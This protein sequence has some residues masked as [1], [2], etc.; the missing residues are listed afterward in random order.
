MY[1]VFF[2]IRY[3]EILAP[4]IFPGQSDLLAPTL[5]MSR[6]ILLLPLCA[7]YDRLWGDLY[8]YLESKCVLLSH[9]VAEPHSGPPPHHS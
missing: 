3:Y 2:I 9:A 4:G 1:Q 7:S 6:A 5:G 8:L